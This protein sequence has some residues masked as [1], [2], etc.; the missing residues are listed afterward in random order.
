MKVALLDRLDTIQAINK[1]CSK[2]LGKTLSGVSTQ[3]DALILTVIESK[4]ISHGINR[5]PLVLV[6]V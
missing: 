3:I 6:Y 1:Q 2:T 4:A 5:G